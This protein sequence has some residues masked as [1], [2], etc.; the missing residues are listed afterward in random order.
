MTDNNALRKWFAGS[1]I[2]IGLILLTP[3]LIGWRMQTAARKITQQMSAP[4]AKISLEKDLHLTQEQISKITSLE[5]S[6]ADEMSLHCERHCSARLKIGKI[7]EQNPSD[8]SSLQPL[9]TEVGEA[10]ANAEQATMQHIARVCEIL[11]PEQKARF[12]KK[13][14]GNI[15]ATCPDPFIK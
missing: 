9:G 13:I 7:L 1:L 14:A 6:Y 2:L 4:L 5:K 11:T 10:Y 15:A 3:W 8:L 12:L